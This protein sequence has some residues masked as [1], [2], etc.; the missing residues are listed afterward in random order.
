MFIYKILSVLAY[1]FVE[2]W[3]FYRTFK[4]KENKKRLMERFGRVSVARP[5][6][7]MI[8]IHAVSIGEANSALIMIER[9]LAKY[10]DVNIVLTTTTTSSAE[11]ISEKIKKF[12]N[13]VIHQFLPIDSLFCVREFLNYWQFKKIFFVESEIWPNL[14]YESKLLESEIFLIN[15]RISEKSLQRWLF[16]KKFLFFKIFDAFDAIYAQSKD[17]QEKIQKLTKNKVLFIGNLK[18]QA[19]KLEFDQ[20]EYLKLTK[21]IGKRP[22]FLCASTHKGEEQ[23]IVDC[24]KE[25]VAKNKDLL[26]IIIPRHPNRLDEICEI[27]DSKINFSIRSKKEAI[28]KKTQIYIADTI[29]ELGLFFNLTDFAFIG[30]SLVDVGGHNPMEAINLDCAVI[31]GDKTFNFKDIYNELKSSDGCILINSQSQLAEE[32]NKILADKKI[33]KNLLNNAKKIVKKD[34]FIDKMLEK[35]W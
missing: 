16:L 35:I 1:P 24:H 33:S 34:E 10:K 15:A 32:V 5:N 7:D 9:I 4:G 8:W 21:Q 14:I 25:L 2:I 12:N 6:A 19:N 23:I 30:G 26:T 11:I 29:N 27:I 31:S 13:K 22:I 28:T 20:E 3:L 18:T 17:E